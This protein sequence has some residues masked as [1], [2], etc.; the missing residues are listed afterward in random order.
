MSRLAQIGQMLG[1][2]F[3]HRTARENNFRAWST[4]CIRLPA[5]L[6]QQEFAMRPFQF[7]LALALAV[8]GACSAEDDPA[9]ETNFTPQPCG[10][11]PSVCAASSTICA[12]IET[13]EGTTL[14]IC[15]ESAPCGA[16]S[17]SSGE[18][19]REPHEDAEVNCVAERLEPGGGSQ[20]GAPIPCADDPSV[21]PGGTECAKIETDEGT[22]LPICVE[23]A[24]C[25]ELSCASGRCAKAPETSPA[26][27]S[28]VAE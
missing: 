19:A 16:L 26:K 2:Y 8:L 22:T 24:D 3:A 25:G 21:C 17:C 10:D 5:N 20:G 11:D 14:P 12:S 18:C 13:K 6:G 23:P 1:A 15:V 28:C 27:T 4:R 7:C 9:T